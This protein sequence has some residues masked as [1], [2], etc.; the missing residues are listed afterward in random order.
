MP[1]WLMRFVLLPAALVIIACLPG[2]TPDYVMRR[3][4]FMGLWFLSA[5]LVGF[6][7]LDQGYVLQLPILSQFL[8]YIGSRSYALYLLHTMCGRFEDDLGQQW[9]AYRALIPQDVLYPWRR[10]IAM[11]LISVVAA[12]VLHRVVERP[13]MRLGAILIDP[14]RRAAF[15]VTTRAKVLLVAGAVLVLLLYFRHGIM[16]RLGPRNLAYRMPVAQSSHEDG[17]PWGEALVNGELES[18]YGTH[19]KQQD[20]PWVTIDLGRPRDIGTIRVYN[21]ADGFQDQQLPLELSVSNDNTNFTVI[22]KRETM[23][24]QAFPWRIR[25]DGEPMRYVRLQVPRNTFLCLSEVEVFEGQG[26]AHLP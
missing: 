1:R 11:F 13:F 9:P 10:A 7:S 18:E 23:F 16:L 8:E 12:E 6:A 26:M 5:I 20:N 22:A 3:E 24:T 17:K 15:R 21:R 19:T 25:V 14:E 4:G 2:A